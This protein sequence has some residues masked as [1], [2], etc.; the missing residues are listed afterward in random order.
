MENE[1]F[2]CTFKIY[3][4]FIHKISEGIKLQRFVIGQYQIG[5]IEL[6]KRILLMYDQKQHRASIYPKLPHTI[7]IFHIVAECMEL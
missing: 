1:Q 2:I 4:Y 6:Q 7:Q 3:T 5:H